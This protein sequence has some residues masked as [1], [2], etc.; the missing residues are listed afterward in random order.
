MHISPLEFTAD[1]TELDHAEIDRIIAE[2]TLQLGLE[3]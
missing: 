1:G 3:F 2:L